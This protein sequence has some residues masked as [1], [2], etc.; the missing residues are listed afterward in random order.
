MP[1]KWKDGS[2]KADSGTVLQKI[3]ESASVDVEREKVSNPFSTERHEGI[4]VL[5][6]MLR[7]PDGLNYDSFQK[8]MSITQAINR[9]VIDKDFS[10]DHFLLKL[11]EIAAEDSE[12]P[13]AEYRLVTSLSVDASF[14]LRTW[15][16]DGCSI[17]L[18]AGELPQKYHSRIP[19]VENSTRKFKEDHPGYSRCIV[20]LRSK[21]ERSAAGKA[22]RALDVFR[23]YCN[24]LLN[25]HSQIV[26]APSGEIPV[27]GV[28]TGECHTLHRKTGTVIHEQLWFE[29]N[30]KH[31]TTV[32]TH[33][34]KEFKE[35]FQGLAQLI[36]KCPYSN[37]LIESLLRYVRALDETDFNTSFLRLWAAIECLA[38]PCVFRRT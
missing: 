36:D 38:C 19:L 13:E 9:A 2:A 20:S 25:P 12:K 3:C 18:L 37:K 5:Q 10:P 22:L 8:R 4:A 27:N 26:F 17:R 21:N 7:F 16:F 15:Q 33:S 28:R 1:V 11:N 24:L 34:P 29:P 32:K 6:T 23:G 14:P 31:T 30:F 35:R